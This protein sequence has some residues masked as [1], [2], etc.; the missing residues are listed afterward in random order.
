M[1]GSRWAVFPPALIVCRCCGCWFPAFPL[2]I[3]RRPQRGGLWVWVSVL[4][5]FG[6]LMVAVACSS[7]GS[8]SH[9]FP[10]LSFFLPVVL[11]VSPSGWLMACL[12]PAG[13]VC[14]RVKVVFILVRW[15]L[16]CRGDAFSLAL[17]R[18]ALGVLSVGPAGVASCVAWPRGVA[19]FGGVAVW[20]G[21]CVAVCPAFLAP[22]GWQVCASGVERAVQVFPV[23]WLVEFTPFPPFLI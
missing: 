4:S 8:L 10:P 14:G 11:V 22:P 13:G 19:R 15:W 16:C 20:P 23:R 3:Y 21:G 2:G 1:W 18:R 5:C 7:R 17:R 12:F 9:P 6:P